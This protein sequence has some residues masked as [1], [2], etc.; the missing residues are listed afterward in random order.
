MRLLYLP[1]EYSQQRQRE[2]PSHIYPVLMAMEAEWYRKKGHFVQWGYPFPIG[3]NRSDWDKIIE[4]P[5]GLPF[6]SLP[7][8][9]RVF[10]HWEKY[11]DNGNFK[12]LPGT[13]IQSARDCWWSKCHFCSWAKKYPKVETRPVVSVLDEIGECIK[14][15]ARDIFDD[16]GTFPVGEW[17]H[18]FCEGM[19]A[20]GYNKKVYISCNMRFGVLKEEDYKLMKE[21]NFRMILYGLESIHQ[22]TIDKLNKGFYL[23]DCITDVFRCNKYGFHAH[24]AVM[25]GYPW[26]T[27]KEEEET[28]NSIIYALEKNHIQ[29]AQGSVYTPSEGT[30]PEEK[31][32]F[33]KKCIRDIYSVI[34]NPRFLWNR[35]KA[36]RE[37]DDV[38]YMIRGGLKA[39]RR[40]K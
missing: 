40:T 1:N 10:T 7:H 12:H 21:A 5:E 14:L 18:K 38:R 6:L 16:S 22:K 28:K 32:V 23:P 20:R 27:D 3:I 25:F 37:M 17:L 13:Y 39:F 4:E 2:K 24:H 31:R 19:I 33:A 8:P 30:I 34:Y 29:S 15:G 11:Q 35:F 9:D 36:I 26:E